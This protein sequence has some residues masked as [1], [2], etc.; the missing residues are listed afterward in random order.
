MC[1]MIQVNE[2]VQ[3]PE[4]ALLAD[5]YD[6][7]IVGY[8]EIDGNMRV[9][10][11]YDLCVAILTIENQWSEDEAIEWMDFNVVSAYVGPNTPLF[12]YNE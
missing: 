2:S 5:G 12:I 4:G 11:R 8:T 9:V 6:N 1:E 7:A 3:V 10:Y